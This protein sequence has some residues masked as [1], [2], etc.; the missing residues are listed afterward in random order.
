LWYPDSEAFMSDQAMEN[1]E[2]YGEGEAGNG[3]R[4][5][6]VK[7]WKEFGEKM[8]VRQEK[9]GWESMEELEQ[10]LWSWAVHRKLGGKE[11]ESEEEE[12]AVK[13]KTTKKRSSNVADLP[14]AK[15]S[16]SK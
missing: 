3:K 16:K 4:D 14:A 8:K 7:A 6:T 12:P 2:A 1:V 9:E 15:K 5:Y 11:E 10:A 13:K